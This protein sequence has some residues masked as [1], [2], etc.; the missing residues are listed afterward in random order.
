VGL[1]PLASFDA[2]PA[3]YSDADPAFYSDADPG[4]PASYN[5]AYLDLNPI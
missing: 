4:V 5:D 3:F 1:D 2:D